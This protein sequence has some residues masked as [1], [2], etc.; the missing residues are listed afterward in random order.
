M[1]EIAL[2]E[3]TV[4]ICNF[5]NKIL[6]ETSLFII[7]SFCHCMNIQVCLSYLSALRVRNVSTPCNYF[8][9]FPQFEESSNETVVTSMVTLV[10]EPDDDT[11]V[12]KCKAE[13]PK[14]SGS[15]LEDSLS[16]NVVCK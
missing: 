1:I 5:T 4:W 16:L 10:P 9:C 6:S 2:E 13:N 11:H 8:A 12:L 14:I 7:H 15:S 3:E